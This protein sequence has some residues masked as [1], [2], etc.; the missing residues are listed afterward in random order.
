MA[1][2]QIVEPH[3]TSN[4]VE[5][6]TARYLS[7]G[8]DGRP[9]ETPGGLFARVADAVARPEERYG[10]DVHAFAERLHRAMV[11]LE[12]LP[13]SP[14]LM[15][16]GGRV[17]QLAGC[18]VARENPGGIPGARGQCRVQDREPVRA[19]DPDGRSGHVRDGLHPGLQGHN[20]Y[21]Q[22][23]RARQVLSALGG[24]T[25]ACPDCGVEFAEGSSLCRICGFT[26][27]T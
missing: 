7:R 8:P 5:V 12:F 21:R 27:G 26:H 16:A 3:L 23:S 20:V 9:T 4:A 11:R 22:G 15:N 25:G 14:T 24:R 1:P 18:F 17:P 10:S 13:N 19:R 6:L 2:I